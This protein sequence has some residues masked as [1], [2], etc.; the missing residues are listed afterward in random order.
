MF[1]FLHKNWSRKELDGGKFAEPRDDVNAPDLYIPAMAFITYILIL[2]FAQGKAGKFSPEII[3]LTAS[4][5][6]FVIILE[7]AVV[8]LGLYA[9]SAKATPSICDLV[10]YTS[11]IYVGVCVDLLVGLFFPSF[12]FHLTTFLLSSSM[13]VFILRCTTRVV[14]GPG[15]EH[16]TEDYNTTRKYFLLIIGLMQLVFGFFL[17]YNVITVSPV[18]YG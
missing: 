13:A 1:P 4:S 18:A 9:L 11:Y 5:G 8:K 2:G 15:A 6:L 14:V 17:C 12:V 3:G 16:Q 7:I 10:A